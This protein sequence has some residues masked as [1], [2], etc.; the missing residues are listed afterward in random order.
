MLVASIGRV[1]NDKEKEVMGGER[2]MTAYNSIGHSLFYFDPNSISLEDWKKLGLN[3]KTIHTIINYR[4]KGGRFRTT[5][6]LKKIYGLR[7]GEFNRIS[8]YIRIENRS[9]MKKEPAIPPTVSNEPGPTITKPLSRQKYA[10]IDINLSDTTAW[11]ALPGIG[12]KLASRIVNFREKLG[13]FYSIEQVAETFGL[14]D[15]TFQ[16]IRSLLQ[17]GPVEIKKISI[18]SV[19]PEELRKHPYIRWALANAI[20]AYRNEHGVFKQLEELKNIMAI[21]EGVYNKIRNYLTL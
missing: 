16:K 13:G 10:S 1:K 2:A 14:P 21:T 20:I 9:A 18:N 5:D 17:L 6:D 8:A 15:S 11:I 3:E 7:E 19:S 4:N 12:S